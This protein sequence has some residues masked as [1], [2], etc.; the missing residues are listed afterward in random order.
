VSRLDFRFV[1]LLALFSIAEGGVVG[2]GE[3]V[4]S[5]FA[6]TVE[7]GDTLAG[8]AARFAVRE[9]TLARENHLPESRRLAAGQQI[10]ID[11]RHVVPP[12][13]GEGILINV[14]QGMLFFFEAGRCVASHPVGLGRRTWQTPV[15]HFQVERKEEEPVWVVPRSIQEEMRRKGEKVLERVPHCDENPLGEYW[16]G[17]SIPGYGIHGTI[18]PESVYHFQ[19]HGCIRMR[20]EDVAALYPRIAVGT[21]VEIVYERVLL[22]TASD[23]TI[24]LEVHPD[25]YRRSRQQALAI[26]K[27]LAANAVITTAV[28][29]DLAAEVAAREDGIA[30]IVSLREP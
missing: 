19:T 24:F 18:A 8:I 7:A 6:Y 3:I 13:P 2:T 10:D 30:R 16:I 14:P 25:V 17:L 4:G 9:R 5:R 26:A 12:A 28:D 11:D 29:C 1:V 22:G 21:P 15:G 23:G 27:L 20:P